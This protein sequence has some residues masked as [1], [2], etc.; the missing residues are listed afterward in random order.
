MTSNLWHELVSF[1][2]LWAAWRKAGRGKRSRAAAA[3]FERDL[4]INL[5]GL[6]DELRSGAYCP[7]DYASFYIHD[8][9][10]RL[11]SAAPFRD[12]VVHHALCNVIEPLFER[13]FIFD[14]Y[15]NRAGKGTHR[16]LDRCTLRPRSDK[17]VH[18]ASAPSGGFGIRFI[19][20]L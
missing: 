13:K 12:R 17:A 9:K 10:K 14:T 20:L 3:E 18:V 4:E 5:C 19:T 1:E 6:R 2:N 7:G 8:P 15:A 11:I 16:A